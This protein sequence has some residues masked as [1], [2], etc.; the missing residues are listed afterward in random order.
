[1]AISNGVEITNEAQEQGRPPNLWDRIGCE[2]M[3]A[4]NSPVARLR[5][6]IYDQG[7]PRYASAC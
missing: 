4:E 2:A 1:M 5:L 7:A 3:A 6:R